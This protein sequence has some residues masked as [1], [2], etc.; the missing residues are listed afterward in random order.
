MKK[1][2]HYVDVL[3]FLFAIGVV[4]QHSLIPFIPNGI[5]SFIDVCCLRLAIPFFFVASGFFLGNK[6]YPV[7]ADAGEKGGGYCKR[8]LKKL[9]V[10]EALSIILKSIFLLL[11]GTSWRSLIKIIGRSVLFYPFGALWYIQAVI[12]AVIILFPF[13][14][15]GKEAYAICLSLPLYGFALLCNRY[16]FLVS[17]TPAEKM[18]LRFNEVFAG[19]RNGLLYGMLFVA[20]GL[21]IAKHWAVLSSKRFLTAAALVV[22]YLLFITEFFLLK[23]RV[24]ADDASLHIMTIFVCPLLFIVA[25]QYNNCWISN[26]KILRNLSTSI[27]LL[28]SPIIS[29]LNIISLLATG[30]NCPVFVLNILLFGILFLVIYGAYK[31]K[32]QPFY[33]LLT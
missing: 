24:G 23:G 20:I 30:Q 32:K 31:T 1:T 21:L 6:L 13:V 14:K 17:Q 26:T 8:L 15:R 7:G 19:P 28:H 33:D 22:A 18:V 16:F 5:Y 29:C 27:Y 2:Y 11:T 9:V 10:F 12:V 4:L 3:K 25:A